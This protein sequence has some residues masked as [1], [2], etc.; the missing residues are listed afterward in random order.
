[1][2]I[3]DSFKRNV[4]R[5]EK[6]RDVKGLI[7]TFKSTNRNVQKKAAE[8]LVR[9]G[10]A[11]VEPVIQALKDENGDVRWAVATALGKMGDT[12]AVEPLTQA[13]RDKDKDVQK[14]AKEA[15]EKIKAKKR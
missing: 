8:A 3:F 15:L 10:E 11:A 5:M 2:R 9:I 14:A 6:E 13:L 1:M 7:G 4:E 12:R